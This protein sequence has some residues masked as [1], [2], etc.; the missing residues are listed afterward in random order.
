MLRKRASVKRKLQAETDKRKNLS[1][2]YPAE[3][4]NGKSDHKKPEKAHQQMFLM[5][6]SSTWPCWRM[7][8][9]RKTRRRVSL[10][11]KIKAEYGK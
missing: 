2:V 11:I 4:K 7:I 9:W 6:S 1:V 10:A 3:E 5:S 8:L